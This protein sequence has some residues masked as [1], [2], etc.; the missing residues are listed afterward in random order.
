MMDSLIADK[1]SGPIGRIPLSLNVV[2]S[3][4]SRA[5]RR[6]LKND[7][8][9]SSPLK[10]GKTSYFRLQEEEEDA[11]EY[12]RLKDFFFFFLFLFHMATCILLLMLLMPSS[13]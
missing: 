5:L 2:I 4:R 12:L 11:I 9:T 10:L 7:F 1:S 8:L 6:C 3:L 13:A